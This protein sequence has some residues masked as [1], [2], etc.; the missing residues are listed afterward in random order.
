MNRRT[1]L[2]SLAVLVICGGILVLF[3]DVELSAIRWIN[4]GPLAGHSERHSE[5]CR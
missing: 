2:I 1:S 3:T 5:I 4:C